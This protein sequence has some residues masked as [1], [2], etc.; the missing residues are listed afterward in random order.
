VSE[1]SLPDA[2]ASLH[3][4]LNWVD[5]RFGPLRNLDGRKL[6]PP[7]P[8]WWAYTC[9]LARSPVGLWFTPNPAGAAGTSLEAA[10]ALDRLLGEAVERYSA[11]NAPYEVGCI[12]LLPAESVLL[13]RFPTCAA[14]ESCP[15]EFRSPDPQIPLTHVPVQG[16]LDNRQIAIPA[17]YVHLNFQP[18][19]PEPAITF[20][21][22]TGLAFHAQLHQ[23]LWN[24]LCEVAERDALMLAWLAQRPLS[25]LDVSSAVL[26]GPL[27]SRLQRLSAAGL[28]TYLFD[29][30]WDFQVPTVFC[31]LAAQRYPYFVAGAACRADPVSACSKALDEAVSARL[32]CPPLVRPHTLPSLEDFAWVR[33]LEQHAFLY[34][35]WQAAPALDF[36]LHS[37]APAVA[38][39]DFV[40]RSWWRAPRDMT[41]LV[42]IAAKLDALGLSILWTEVTAAEA[43]VFGHVVKV[44]VPE[45][46]PLA[47]DHSARWLATP[48]LLRAAGLDQPALKAFNPYPHPFA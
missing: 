38:F 43:A 6:R 15:A 28:T 40:R 21:I 30:T 41:E 32:C 34:A 4:V 27:S 36:L 35:A 16:L 29:M 33:S 26:P 2:P 3:G 46:I 45:M 11:L 18:R 8:G 20:S 19:P 37:S 17:G 13:A 42:A 23:A 48:R 22:S 12:S 1:S 5:D 7:E 31:I 25:P 24:G 44:I 10:E 14:E 9:N 39:H 47:M